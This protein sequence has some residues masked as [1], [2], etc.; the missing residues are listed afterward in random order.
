MTEEREVRTDCG[1]GFQTGGEVVLKARRLSDKPG[2]RGGR[3][4]GGERPRTIGLST[5]ETFVSSPISEVEREPRGV[6]NLNCNG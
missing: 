4:S 3:Q 1:S 5:L 2:Q 6:L